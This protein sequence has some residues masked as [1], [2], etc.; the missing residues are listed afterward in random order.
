ML[1]FLGKL[2]MFFDDKGQS[3]TVP[4][5]AMGETTVPVPAGTEA[6]ETVSV[7]DSVPVTGNGGIVPT[8]SARVLKPFSVEDE[9]LRIKDICHRIVEAN[10][11]DAPAIWFTEHGGARSRKELFGENKGRED[12]VVNPCFSKK[13]T[14]KELAFAIAKEC[15]HLNCLHDEEKM[16]V[17]DSMHEARVAQTYRFRLASVVDRKNVF[18]ADRLALFFMEKAGFGKPDDFTFLLN[19]VEYG[20]GF[21]DVKRVDVLG[22]LPRVPERVAAMERA[23]VSSIRF[24]RKEYE[25]YVDGL[26]EIVDRE[27]KYIYD[28]QYRMLDDTTK[29]RVYVG[30]TEKQQEELS[31]M[32]FEAEKLYLARALPVVRE[33]NSAFIGYLDEHGKDGNLDMVVATMPT[34][35]KDLDFVSY[36]VSKYKERQEF[37]DAVASMTGELRTAMDVALRRCGKNRTSLRSRTDR[38]LSWQLDNQKM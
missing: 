29:T 12:I 23:D 28:N 11:L 20:F 8:E 38:Q 15:A 14:D 32:Q 9:K 33:C 10:G 6:S 37:A 5:S 19:E 24:D 27:E 31:A 13:L 3:G 18:E 2:K 26:R 4:V 7:A 35:V 30:F 25:S 36:E 34:T 22:N 17:R 1:G 16:L 21:N